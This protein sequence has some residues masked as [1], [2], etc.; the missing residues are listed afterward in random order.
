M[1]YLSLL[2]LSIIPLSSAYIVANY[3]MSFF[4]MAQQYSTA[5]HM[6]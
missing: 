4:F 1:C 2:S 3:K 5:I 6:P